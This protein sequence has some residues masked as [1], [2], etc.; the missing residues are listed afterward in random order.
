MNWDGL[1]RRPRREDDEH[2]PKEL[3]PSFW[4]DVAASRRDEQ[5][6]RARSAAQQ[7]LLVLARMI[8]PNSTPHA[9][10]AKLVEL[11]NVFGRAAWIPVEPM[12]ITSTAQRALAAEAAKELSE[13]LRSIVTS[14][15][16]EAYQRLRDVTVAL[17]TRLDA[18]VV[19]GALPPGHPAPAT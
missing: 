7:R 17:A 19:F 8:Q 10:L 11:T 5:L 13:A 4:D 18:D 15:F 12:Y 9:Y 6:A 14:P 16:P 1:P 2:R 3:P